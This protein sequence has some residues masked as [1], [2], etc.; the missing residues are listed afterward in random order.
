MGE[1]HEHDWQVLVAGLTDTVAAEVGPKRGDP[2]GGGAPYVLFGHSLGALLAFD[3]SHRML[4][5]GRPPALLAVAGRNGP[6]VPSSHAPVHR[7]SDHEF[8]G[9]MHALGGLPA[10]LLRQ[11][12]LMR[13]FLPI[14][15]ADLRLAEL[16]TRPDVPVLSIPVVAFAGR[17]DPMTDAAGM[18]TWARETT[19][20][21][22][23]VF[24]EGGH[25]FL[26]SREFERQFTERIA[27]PTSGV[28][29]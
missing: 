28:P 13:L 11:P 2:E 12:E 18:L 29:K 10:E 21:C 5:R 3:I 24:L 4:A 16:Y 27:R 7:L 20:V 22:E 14:I 25:F 9:A 15:R 6:S 8:V 26:G 1:P 23:L 19:G 17:Q